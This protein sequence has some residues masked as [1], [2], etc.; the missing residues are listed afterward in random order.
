MSPLAATAERL[1][2]AAADDPATELA[3]LQR[4]LN[5]LKS[6]LP[7]EPQ[8]NRRLGESP[9]LSQ[10]KSA[11]LRQLD[12][13]MVDFVVAHPEW[14]SNNLSGWY[15]A[16]RETSR[17]ETFRNFQPDPAAAV[18]HAKDK[19]TRLDGVRDHF[20]IHL[21]QQLL[22][23]PTNLLLRELHEHDVGAVIELAGFVEDRKSVV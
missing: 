6:D 20:P 16:Y 2:G 8:F 22:I 12:S 19:L 15:R 14:V 4:Q 23:D 5:A 10:A 13:D 7:A 21:Q 1:P 18:A 3:Q 11:R 17:L 9:G